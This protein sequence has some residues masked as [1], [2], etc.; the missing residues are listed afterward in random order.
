MD[1]H[2]NLYA[3]NS[4]YRFCQQPF[5]CHLT[6]VQKKGEQTIHITV[7][8]SRHAAKRGQKPHDQNAFSKRIF[9][10]DML[11]QIWQSKKSTAK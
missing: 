9:Y 11:D 8:E 2:S 1:L 3:F 7:K 10:H 4:Y 5:L 6:L